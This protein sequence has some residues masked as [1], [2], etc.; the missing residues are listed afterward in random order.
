M[1]KTKTFRFKCCGCGDDV[2]CYCEIE[3][4]FIT[5][6]NKPSACLYTDCDDAKWVEV[7]TEAVKVVQDTHEEEEHRIYIRRQEAEI[8]TIELQNEITRAMLKEV[9]H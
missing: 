6:D 9:K 2:P 4:K 3:S 7:E 5:E 8:A 1:I